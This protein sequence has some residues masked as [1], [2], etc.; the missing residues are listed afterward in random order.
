MNHMI[1]LKIE[2][3]SCL[4]CISAVARALKSVPGVM[5]ADVDL[6][7]GLARIEGTASPEAL[8]QAVTEAGY[9]AVLAS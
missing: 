1:E 6:T 3:M 9:A 4:H 8:V 2:G 7:S 5:E